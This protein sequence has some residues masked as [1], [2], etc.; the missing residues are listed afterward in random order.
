MKHDAPCFSVDFN[1]MVDSRTVLL[2]ATDTRV[3]ALGANVK[4]CSGMLVNLYMPDL[5]ERGNVDNLVAT[6]V[7]MKNAEAGWSAH[8]KWC[9][10]IDDAGIRPESE[11]VE[12]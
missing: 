8:V 7:V 2:S 9:C 6:G 12:E 10:R 4:L 11:I 3:D 1:E 5:D